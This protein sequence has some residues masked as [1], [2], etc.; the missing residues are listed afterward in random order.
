MSREEK[1]RAMHALW[2]DLAQEDEAVES[3]AW[4]GESLK[5]TEERM[6]SGVERIRDWEEAKEE[7][8]RRAR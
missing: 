1:L 3:P 5:E 8:R 7:L 6:Q 4:H 2:E